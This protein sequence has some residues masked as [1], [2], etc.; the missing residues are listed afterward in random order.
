M[1]KT[2]REI[3]CAFIPNKELKTKVRHFI[4]AIRPWLDLKNVAAIFAA[5]IRKKT[6][7]IIE[8]NECHGECLCSYLKYFKELGYNTHLITTPT[9]LELEPLYNLPPKYMPEKIFQLSPQWFKSF[10]KLKKLKKYSYIFLCTTHNYYYEKSNFEALN[11]FPNLQNKMLVMEHDLRQIKLYNEES[12]LNNNR[13]FV[14]TNFTNNPQ[15]N[16]LSPHY[17]PLAKEHVKNSRQT[18]FITVGALDIK[19]RNITILFDA[20]KKLSQEGIK[21]FKITVIGG[22][23]LKNIPEDIAE[24]F[25]IKSRLNFPDMANELNNADFILALLDPNI[26]ANCNYLHYLTTGTKQLIL[27]FKKPCIVNNEFAKALGF[28]ET[29]SLVYNGNEIHAQMKNA[30]SLKEEKYIDM[31]NELSQKAE[32]IYNNSVNN[33]K[34]V[35]NDK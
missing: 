8:P 23:K 31:R 28:D 7:L 26:N 27:G 16:T 17:F 9:V 14:I 1:R 15:I 32:D 35:I 2:I 3:I 11:I 34:R 29:N 22:G 20:I 25:E 21:N 12:F 19:R 24:F 10:F 5:K 4:G 6:V 18:N 13:L 30:I 33:L